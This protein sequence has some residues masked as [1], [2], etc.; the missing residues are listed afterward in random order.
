MSYTP[1]QELFDGPVDVVGDL[2]GEATAL[3]QLMRKL[4]YDAYGSHPEG[5]RLVFVGDLVDR[6][7]NS[8]AVVEIVAGLMDKGRAQCVLGNHELN[9]LLDERKEGNGWVYP[10]DDDHDYAKGHFVEARRPDPSQRQDILNWFAQLPL[11]LERRDLRVVHASWHQPAIDALREE[12][13]G[14]RELYAAWS[15]RLGRDFR[16][17]GLYEARGAEQQA[18]GK[19]LVDRTA[20]VPLLPA[21]MAID[22]RK[23]TDHPVKALTSG[24]EQPT[25][26]AF[27]GGGKWRMTERVAWWDHYND[28]PA[29]IFGHY[30]RW[31]GDERDAAARSRGPNLFEGRSPWEWLGPRGNAM[32]VDYCA[33]LRWRERETGAFQHIGITAAVRWP[34]RGVMTAG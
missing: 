15:D 28:E 27:F 14:V 6:G 2:H 7:E 16:D 22:V 13:R 32:C 3:A 34:A 24:L 5:R 19:A 18:W 26:R 8:P 12:L 33:G 29:V 23:Q 10:L 21:T 25:R 9:L 17:E 1:I 4:G 11:A 30:W 31:A 20:T